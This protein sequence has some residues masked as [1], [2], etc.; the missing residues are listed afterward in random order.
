MSVS[1]IG[2]AGAGHLP[3]HAGLV[4]FERGASVRTGVAIGRDPDLLCKEIDLL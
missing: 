2:Q 1:L 4:P 3:A